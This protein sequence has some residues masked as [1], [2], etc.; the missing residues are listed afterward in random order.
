M[1]GLKLPWEIVAVLMDKRVGPDFLL[2]PHAASATERVS[3][4]TS[5]RPHNATDEL[6]GPYLLLATDDVDGAL[7]FHSASSGQVRHRV[8]GCLLLAI[9][10]SRWFGS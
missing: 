6:R 8:S 2:C 5:G 4:T 3:T 9:G 7:N 10:Q 1:P